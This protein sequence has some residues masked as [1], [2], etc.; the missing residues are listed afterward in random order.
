MACP[1]YAPTTSR[2]LIPGPSVK[3]Y[4][5][6]VKRR[7]WMAKAPLGARMGWATLA[8]A[9]RRPGYLWKVTLRIARHRRLLFWQWRLAMDFSA[10]TKPKSSSAALPFKRVLWPEW[11]EW[12]DECQ[13]RHEWYAVGGRR[14]A[15]G[16]PECWC[17]KC[18]VSLPEDDLSGASVCSA[19]EHEWLAL[20]E[21]CG[22]QAALVEWWC[23]QLGCDAVGAIDDEDPPPSLM[24]AQHVNRPVSR[25]E[26]VRLLKLLEV[27]EPE[28]ERAAAF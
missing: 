18:G 3:G 12:A 19:E 9:R 2:E 20:Y 1:H 25:R 6:G 23:A 13:D 27:F 28:P 15:S 10:G 11:A 22:N 16:P 21:F 5:A 14:Q 26:F 7:A 24:E 4:H 8:G 17:V